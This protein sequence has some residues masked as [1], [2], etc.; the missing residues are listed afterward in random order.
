[1]MEFFS[2]DRLLSVYEE[3]NYKPYRHLKSAQM[4]AEPIIVRK[5]KV[6]FAKSDYRFNGVKKK[7]HKV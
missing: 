1:M 6:L 2:V 7:I 3:R 4:Y 5:L